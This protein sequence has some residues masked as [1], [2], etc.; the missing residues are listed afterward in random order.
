MAEWKEI[1]LGDFIRLRRG[2][3]LTANERRKGTVP[4]IGSAGENGFHDT[5]LV[6]GPGLTIGR[7]GVGSMGVAT[8]VPTDY[9]P[10]N[11]VLYATDFLGNDPRFA[12]Y[13]FLNFD[14]RRYNSGSAQ[15]TLN[16][17]YI[18]PIA[19]RIPDLPEQKVI[20]AMLGA[21]DDK[22]ELNGRM[23]ATLGAMARALFQSWFVDFDP[24]HA[25]ADGRAPVG[26]D[27][28][29]ASLFPA[30]FQ[31][32]E[33]RE[34]PAGWGVRSLDQIANYLNGLA[35]QKFPLGEEP[36]LP[37]NQDC[38]T[39][40]RGQ[41]RCGPVQHGRATRIHNCRWRRP[42]F[43][44]R[45]PGSRALVRRPRRTESTSF[46]GYLR[47]VPQVVLLPLDAPSPRRLSP[48][49]CEQSDNHGS[50]P[51]EAPDRREG[52]SPPAPTARSN[53]PA[54]RAANR[55]THCESNTIPHPRRLARYIASEVS[56]RS[57]N[58]KY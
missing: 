10:H 20:A 14:L 25:K 57:E 13:F 2:H 38:S 29:T 58:Y 31:D 1:Q 44:V 46:Q 23:N 18:Y 56:E 16:R 53:D 9:W 49:R 22:I 55:R 11:T 3:D 36:T 37:G 50:H 30:Q 52:P 6:Q 32:S 41:P 47:C 5:A 15:A 24:V 54:H 43:L 45:Q 48:H 33:L 40:E 12:Y 34:I 4:V 35:L 42:L 28:R 8:Y 19:I 26:L 51:A 7:S 17:N 21:L 39:A 27:E